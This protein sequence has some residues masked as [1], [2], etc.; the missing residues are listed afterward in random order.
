MPVARRG[1]TLRQAE[2][3]DG[4]GRQSCAGHDSVRARGRRGGRR[5][6]PSRGRRLRAGSCTCGRPLRVGQ[7]SRHRTRTKRAI[8]RFRG[9]RPRNRPRGFPPA[10][11]PWRA[12][13][14]VQAGDGASIWWMCGTWLVRTRRGGRGSRCDAFWVTGVKM[15]SSAPACI[16]A[17]L[18]A[19]ADESMA[20]EQ[21][22][23]GSLGVGVEVS[24]MVRG[25]GSMD[26]GDEPLGSLEW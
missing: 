10:P 16:R 2:R 13:G 22:G 26:R 8:R 1:R 23:R 11:A 18:H 20:R 17:V 24:L 15:A 12:W 19:H 9:A 5:L 25:G 4:G 21:L 3:G 6:E 14:P 7:A